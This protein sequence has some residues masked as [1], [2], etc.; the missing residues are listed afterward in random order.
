MKSFLLPLAALVVLIVSTFSI[1]R[2]QPLRAASEPPTPP[3]STDFEHRVAA[4]GLVEAGSEN[5]SLS[6]HLPGVVE[7]VLVTVGQEVKTGEALVKLDTRAL[8]AALL[9]RQGELLG[10]RA[11]VATTRARAVKARA[12][13]A[14]AQRNLKFAESV[15]DSR[16][17]SAEEVTR[18]RSA[19]EIA[20][21][22]LEA[23]QAEITSAEAS[24]KVAEATLQTVETDLRRSTITAPIDGRI[25]QV[26]I[27]PGEYATA[28]P[29]NQA[30]LILG[31]VNPLHVR[32]DIDEH[33]A[34]RVRPEATAT[35]QVR[36]NASLSSPLKFVRFEPLVVPKQSLT[37]GATERVDTR[38]LQAVY[39]VEN[40]NLPLF[41]GQ[42]MDVFIQ[43]KEREIAAVAVAPAG[44]GPRH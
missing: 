39:R 24:V 30:W 15:G 9:E 23:A 37:G 13:L 31:N 10:R 8:E 27:R 14:D 41:V 42:Q 19:V 33:E 26:R 43:T 44:N 6:A 35:A 11:A 17:I 36:G 25:L 18:R 32:V 5:I 34:W 21:A 40:G 28:G 22:E 16:S 3:P 29:S 4:V 20:S 1:L 2:T 38:V 7:K 12:L